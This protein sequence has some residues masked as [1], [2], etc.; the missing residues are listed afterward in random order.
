MAKAAIIELQD[1]LETLRREAYDEGYKAAMRAVVGFTIAKPSQGIPRSASVTAAKPALPAPAPKQRQPRQ[2][3]AATTPT[4]R[5]YGR[6]DNA[7]Q[8]MSGLHDRPGK[9]GDIR[10]AL[11]DK[12]FEMAYASIRHALGQLQARGEVSV[13]HTGKTWTSNT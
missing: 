7:R 2:V 4:R 5:R 9:A 11:A 12:G 10:K 13:A 6:G 8:V 1:H 3:K